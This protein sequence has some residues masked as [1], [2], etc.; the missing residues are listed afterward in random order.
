MKFRILVG[1]LMV[2][3]SLMAC[4]KIGSSSL[5]CPSKD[6]F[7][8]VLSTFQ[9]GIS[10][11]NIQKS[12]ID[13]LCEV[14]IQV[15]PEQKGIFYVDSKGQYIITGRIL[16]LEKKKDLTAERLEAVNRRF[17]SSQDMSELEKRVAFTYGNS[18]NYVYFITDP[19][20]P[21]CKKA[22][23]VLEQ[24]VKEGKISVK[25]VLYPLEALHPKAKNKAI[26]LICD[27]KGF[28]ELKRGY[29]S[30]NQCAEGEKKVSETISFL[31]NNLK[32]RATPTFV[33]PDGEVKMGFLNSETI[34]NKFKKGS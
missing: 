26:A 21:F 10:I 25:V 3:F 28:E 31:S 29:E 11:D 16:D 23:N 32:I 14:T 12:P 34:L 4:D 24:L 27:G 7:Q 18:S 5:N 6:K 30:K 8:Q 15:S 17:L 13:G 22:E 20:C 19:D 33:F 9:P 2:I 1:I